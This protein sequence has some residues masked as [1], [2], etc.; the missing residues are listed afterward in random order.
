[1]AAAV[2]SSE[3]NAL[4]T[5]VEVIRASWECAAGTTPTDDELR[6]LLRVIVVRRYDFADSGVHRTQA[7]EMLRAES[8]VSDAFELLCSAGL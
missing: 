8:A 5:I 4:A 3:R 7:E 2:N 6:A 1:M